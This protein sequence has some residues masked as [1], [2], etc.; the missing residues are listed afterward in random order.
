MAGRKPEFDQYA[1]RYDAMHRDSIRASGE[2]PDYF[3]AYKA[4]FLARELATLRATDRPVRL[5]DFGCGIGNLVPHVA[6]ELNDVDV[7]G[8]DPS[9]ASIDIARA[10]HGGIARF[11]AIVDDRIPCADEAFDAVV[12][13]CVFHHI[14]PA[15]RGH[16]MQEI[17][18][19]LRPGG[20]AVVF[21]H[22]PFNPLTRKAVRDCPFDED[23]ILLRPAELQGLAWGCGMTAVSTRYIV[24][25]PRVLSGLRA[26]EPA[27]SWLPAGAQYAVLARKP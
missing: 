4:A 10:N 1:S 5:L 7:V 17:R 8:V 25:F 3:A 9:A 14:A 21:E 12:V 16:W 13:A 26:L 19:V 6:R 27:L 24:F 2:A 23:A 18:R 22:N 11:D 15:D 20:H